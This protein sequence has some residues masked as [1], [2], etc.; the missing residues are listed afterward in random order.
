[1]NSSN[2][3]CASCGSV[4]V[5]GDALCQKCGK[6]VTVYIEPPV[7]FAA[8]LPAWSIEPPMVVIRRK[9]RI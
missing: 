8:G 6:P 3:K 5:T 9:A 7:A 4:V 2:T 1:M